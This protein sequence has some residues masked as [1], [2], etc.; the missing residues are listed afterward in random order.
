MRAL[1]NDYK[2]CKIIEIDPAD[3]TSPYGIM[4]EGYDP[5]DP[6]YRTR[7]FY[8]QRDG[9]WIDEIARSA[10]PDSEGG[11]VLFETS[12]EALELLGKLRGQASCA[13]P[14]R[15]QGRCPEN[16]SKLSSKRVLEPTYVF[17]LDQDKPTWVF[18]VGVSF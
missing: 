18:S 12:A 1:T 13:R 2:D 5:N 14:A 15:L 10:R 17:N 9:Q 8:L 16:S 7:M 3:P 11:D 6:T 4:Q